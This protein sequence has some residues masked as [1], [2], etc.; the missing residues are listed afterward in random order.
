M[1]IGP[2]EVTLYRTVRVPEGRAPSNLPPNLG[3]MKVYKVKD[4]R[5]NCPES[6]EDDGVFV[7]LHETE[8]MWMGFRSS[9]PVAVLIGAGGINALTGEKL[10]TKLD[11]DNYVVAPPQ[12]WLDGWKDQDGSVYQFVATQYKGGEGLTVGEQLIGSESKTGGIGIAVFEPKDRNALKPKHAP[13]EMWADG[14]FGGLEMPMGGMKGIVGSSMDM[15]YCCALSDAAPQSLTK[16]SLR[17]RSMMPEMG[18]GKGGK[19]IQKIYPD[20]HGIEAWKD[21]PV[22]ATAIYLVD[23]AIAAEITGDKVADPTVSEEYS[24]KWY[25]LDDEK[26]GD[27]AGTGKFTGLKS[28]VFAGDTT[29]IPAPEPEPAE[30]KP[31]SPWKA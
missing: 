28:A 31:Q 3:T 21:A 2:L 30:A 1:K 12:P 18:V 8:A 10:G 17:A 11:K 16:S 23:A 24:G 27:V 14:G 9:C 7:A 20:P 15:T 4:Y 25:G 22:A 13:T 6:W 19:I 29:N 5:A 26:E